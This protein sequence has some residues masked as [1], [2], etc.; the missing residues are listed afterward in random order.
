MHQITLLLLHQFETTSYTPFLS[1]YTVTVIYETYINIYQGKGSDFLK[2][3][4]YFVYCTVT[5][6][7]LCVQVDGMDG[8]DL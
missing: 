6:S 5:E 8:L 3:M 1:K 4:M 2:Q 7:G